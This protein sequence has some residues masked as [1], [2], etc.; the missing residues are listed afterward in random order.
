MIGDDEDEQN[1]KRSS[2]VGDFLD[3]SDLTHVSETS[4]GHDA[5][6]S[7]DAASEESQPEKKPSLKK[8]AFA[9]VR[10]I[11][12]GGRQKSSSGNFLN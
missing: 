8:R 12:K 10:N 4:I 6:T 9:K 3:K 11:F 1:S 5:D 7:P 2:T